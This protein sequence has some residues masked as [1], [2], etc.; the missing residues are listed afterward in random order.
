MVWGGRALGTQLG[1]SLPTTE[2]FG[3]AWDVSD[4]PHHR[5]MVA[6]GPW[7]GTTLRQLMEQHKQALLG[8]A[9]RR[10]ATFPWL[11]KF[12]DARDWLSVQVHPD[13]EKVKTLWPGEGSKTEAWYV[14]AVQPNSRIYA[15][16]KPNVG[17]AEL[18]R[19]LAEGTVGDCLH[20][21]V[22]QPGDCVFLRAGT[23]H[24]V[25]GGVLMA[26]IQETSDATFRLFD[27]NRVDAQGKSRQ[28]HVE[29][30]FAAIHWDYGPVQPIRD[31]AGGN[32]PQRCN[33]VSCE[34]FSL[35]RISGVSSLAL[36]SL[37]QLQVLIVLSGLGRWETGEKVLPGQVWVLPATMPPTGIQCE[38]P[39]SG[40]LAKLP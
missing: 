14:I 22:P 26:E 12:L 21:F 5:S 30:A 29:E 31:E 9:A 27:W 10:F 8:P 11:I 19:G 7:R 24:A 39:L 6:E 28:L 23:V 35:D 17:P 2:N 32:T 15:G 37:D 16:L 34:C 1:K 36:H 4:H 3:E 20:S 18:R 38:T 13:S 25:G 40:L 33:L